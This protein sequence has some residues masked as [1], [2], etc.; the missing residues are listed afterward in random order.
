METRTRERG[1]G[2]PR[3]LVAFDGS[4]EAWHALEALDRLVDLQAARVDLV[5]VVELPPRG[6]DQVTAGSLADAWEQDARAN[7]GRAQAVLAGKGVEVRTCVRRGDPATELVEAARELQVDLIVIGSHRRSSFGRFM[8]GS[9]SD[10]VVHRFPGMTLVVG[11][12]R[13][14]GRTVRDVMTSLPLVASPDD[15]LVAV[16]RKMV[17]ADA[18][19][20]PLVERDR[21][22][23][24]VTDRDLA[25]RALAGG[26]D[27]TTTRARAVATTPVIT[28]G[29]AEPVRA[30]ALLME[31]HRVRRLVVVEDGHVV[32]VVALG[33]LAE[34]E[35][36]AAE[37]VLVEVSRSPKT[38]AHG[39]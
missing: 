12:G 3:V 31:R 4:D 34:G 24:V 22:V 5:A 8:L 2:E 7:V 39:G 13:D 15:N 30:A 28:I 1:A 19:L 11:P 37:R 29:P 17:A 26:L 35:L 14:R 10:A 23:G 20:I 38:L 25:T 16:A 36:P 6:A 21:V 32:G 33:D 18:G 9:V 27:P